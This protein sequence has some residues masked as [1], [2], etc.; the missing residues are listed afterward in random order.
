MLELPVAIFHPATLPPPPPDPF[1]Y[2]APDAYTVDPVLSP[3]PAP[4]PH[5]HSPMLMLYPEPTQSPLYS[6]PLPLS[7]APGQLVI[8]P[9]YGQLWL[10]PPQPPAYINGD[11]LYYQSPPLRSASANPNPNPNLNNLNNLPPM[12]P[13]GLPISGT[14]DNVLSSVSQHQHQHQ[15]QTIIGMEH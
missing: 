3:A 14:P 4:A 6:L 8:P 7:P 10:S 2:P 5:L 11:P 1:P 15:Q 12:I 9:H 13:S